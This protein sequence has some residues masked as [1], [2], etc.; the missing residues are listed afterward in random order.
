MNPKNK[1]PLRWLFL[2]FF[3]SVWMFVLGIWVGRG[4]APVTFDTKALIKELAEL[5]ETLIKQEHNSYQSDSSEKH[6]SKGLDFYEALKK[7][8][9][10]NDDRKKTN[11]LQKKRSAQKK[12]PVEKKKW[13]PKKKE[14]LKSVVSEKNNKKYTIQ[15]A[16]LKDAESADNM[17]SDL[18]KKGYLAYKSLA[19]V[20]GKGIWYRVRIGDFNNDK[21]AAAILGKLKKDNMSAIVVLR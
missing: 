15:V 18:K 14:P 7:T 19:K 11:L 6:G 16:S 21:E 17:V 4:T 13:T 20:P 5:K 8:E 2:F 1:A 10:L 3:T 12:A 9:N